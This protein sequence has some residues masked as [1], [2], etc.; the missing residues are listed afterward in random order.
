MAEILSTRAVRSATIRT[1]LDVEHVLERL[2]AVAGDKGPQGWRRA[3][4]NG[5]FRFGQVSGH[6]LL[7]D[8]HFNNPRNP[9]T[10]AVQARVT[11]G[12][13]WRR[14]DLSLRAHSPFV[15]GWTLIVL[16]LLGCEEV[17]THGTHLGWVFSVL[18]FVLGVMAFV[19]LLYIP[20]VVAERVSARLAHAVQGSV[21]RGGQW[22]VPKV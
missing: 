10:F 11:D 18:I 17:Y 13:D 20:E 3:L 6:E 21:R 15:E 22:V 14:I 5:Y 7:I 4:A 8:Y 16:V 9:Q 1:R 2:R 12:G 19:N